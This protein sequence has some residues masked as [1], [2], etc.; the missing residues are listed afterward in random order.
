MKDAASNIANK[1]REGGGDEF[2]WSVSEIA[3]DIRAAIRR[4]VNAERE[5]CVKCVREAFEVN[6]WCSTTTF[7]AEAE[8]AIQAKRPSRRK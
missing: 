2:K 6:T 3:A 4:A 5:R 7:A 8:K 1:S